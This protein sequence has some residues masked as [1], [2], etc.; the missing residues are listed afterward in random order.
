MSRIKLLPGNNN[1]NSNHRATS[2]SKQSIISTC[3]IWVR[4]F[5]SNKKDRIS[6]PS[7]EKP[8]GHFVIACTR[9]SKSKESQLQSLSCLDNFWQDSMTSHYWHYLVVFRGFYGS[10]FVLWLCFMR[11]QVIKSCNL[12]CFIWFMAV[13][14]D[15][16][17]DVIVLLDL[18]SRLLKYWWS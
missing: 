2:M 16:S 13:I 9:H 17:S 3:L 4:C 1:N 12:L 14:I 18:C 6:S 10:F 8:A 5:R 15:S 7:S 11:N